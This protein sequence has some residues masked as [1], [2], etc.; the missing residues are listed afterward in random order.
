MQEESKNQKVFNL[1]DF[2]NMLGL[3]KSSFDFMNHK[4]KINPLSAEKVHVQ[5]VLRLVEMIEN[6]FELV[7]SREEFVKMV[8]KAIDQSLAKKENQGQDEQSMSLKQ[9]YLS[10]VS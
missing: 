8:E 6:I 9:A 3:C 1:Q 4:L 7:G 5:V 10:T 2:E